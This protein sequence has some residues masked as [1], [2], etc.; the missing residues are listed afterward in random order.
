MDKSKGVE[1]IFD[2]RLVPIEAVQQETVAEISNS[3]NDLD[4]KVKT[5]EEKA[6]S[7]KFQ[8]DFIQWIAIGIIIILFIAIVGL[9]I[10]AYRFHAQSYIDLKNSVNELQ[11]GS[12]NEKYD[13]LAEKILEIESR[14][15]G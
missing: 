3:I 12:L 7:I 6:K 10:D 15:G 14:F 9:L 5:L 13:M 11:Q 8:T 4:N 2:G 1:K